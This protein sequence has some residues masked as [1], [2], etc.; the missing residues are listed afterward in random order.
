MQGEKSKTIPKEFISSLLER[1]NPVDFLK[2]KIQVKKKG[3]NYLANCP[4]HGEKTPSFSINQHKNYYHCFGCGAHGDLINFLQ[5][6]SNLSFVE[7]VEELSSFIGIEIP[8]AKN[9]IEIAQISKENQILSLLEKIS[10][11]YRFNLKY[12]KIAIDYLKQRNIKGEIA[13]SFAL[14]FA[15][16]SW[17]SC[18]S[19][20]KLNKIQIDSLYEIGF[21][22]KTKS[23]KFFEKFRFRIMFPIK[24]RRQKII[25]FGARSI[26]NQEPKYLNSSESFIFSKKNELYGLYKIKTN[27][28]ENILLVEGYMDVI[29]LFQHNI[30]N[31]VAALG[32]SFSKFHFIKI[33]Q[34]T[35]CLIFCFDGDKAGFRAAYKALEIS[36]ANINDGNVIKFMFLPKGEDPDS[37]VQKHGKEN[38]LEKQDQALEACD[39]FFEYL[40]KNITDLSKMAALQLKDQAL[41][42]IQ[43]I[44]AVEFKKLMLNLL[45]QK[46]QQLTFTEQN[47]KTQNLSSTKKWQNQTFTKT[48]NNQ[49]LNNNFI[50]PE[51]LKADK[52]TDYIVAI[53]LQKPE[54]VLDLKFWNLFKNIKPLLETHKSLKNNY[55][56]LIFTVLTIKKYQKEFDVK[57]FSNDI[58]FGSSLK[59]KIISLLTKDLSLKD[60][61]HFFALFDCMKKIWA[62]LIDKKMKTLMGQIKTSRLE[63]QKELYKQHNDLLKLKKSITNN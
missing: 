47:K 28:L 27:N 12:S 15:P 13:K 11:Y 29:G 53:L 8:Y 37:F 57:I 4:F 10:N 23:N 33:F 49:K 52:N 7:A 63:N 60:N 19:N 50:K 61:E 20:L 46:M 9:S 22:G 14:G 39:F 18:I 58:S 42:V 43:T 55:D 24:N 48:I 6:F 1:I 5:E 3:N 59:K 45:N 2:T 34:I 36:F 32:T 25:G 17:D 21:L 38:F 51:E 41:K 16:N 56:F 31:S 26:D 30:K 62:K 44:K 40:E 54:L 35:N